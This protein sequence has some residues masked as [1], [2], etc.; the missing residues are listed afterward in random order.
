MAMARIREVLGFSPAYFS[1]VKNAMGIKN[2][3][4]GF[5]SKFA[6]FFKDNPGFRMAD[7]YPK[8]TSSQRVSAN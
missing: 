2:Q 6:D 1:A 3:R 5:L 8:K 4:M 7:V